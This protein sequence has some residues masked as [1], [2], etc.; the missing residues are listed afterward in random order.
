MF[1]VTTPHLKVREAWTWRRAA[2]SVAI[3]VGYNA[4]V[5]YLAR[6]PWEDWNIPLN[7]LCESHTV[8]HI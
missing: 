6:R 2:N 5:K 3:E 4:M 8:Y 7:G 1:V